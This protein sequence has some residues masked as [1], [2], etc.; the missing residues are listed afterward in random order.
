MIVT[1]EYI[2]HNP[3]REET[4]DIEKNTIREHID[5]CGYDPWYKHSE[6]GKIQ[7]FDKLENKLK[8]VWVKGRCLLY[9]AKRRITAARG[10][11]EIHK[12]NKFIITLEGTI[13]ENIINT[14]LKVNIPMM[15]R[16]FYK[17]I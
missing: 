17:K 12:I 13:E 3:L 10:R 8:N 2:F 5:K 1:T 6:R 16:A 15:W 9:Q 14:N 7:F 11:F 4:A